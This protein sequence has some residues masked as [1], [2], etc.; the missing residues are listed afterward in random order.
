[1]KKAVRLFSF[2]RGVGVVGGRGGGEFRRDFFHHRLEIFFQS[3]CFSIDIYSWEISSY[4]L[5]GIRKSER[6]L[7]NRKWK[8]PWNGNA[9]EAIAMVNF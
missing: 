1:M 3:R 5:A 6:R 9:V 4:I 2:F 7:I 8:Q